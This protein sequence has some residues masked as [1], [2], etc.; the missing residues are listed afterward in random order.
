[1]FSPTIAPGLLYILTRTLYEL[2][3]SVDLAKISTHLDQVVDVFYVTLAE[4]QKI[5]DELSLRHIRDTL[6]ERLIE[7]EA[8]GHTHF[9]R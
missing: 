7:F 5:D 1:M 3:L 6:L 4:G 8:E 9:A 2:G